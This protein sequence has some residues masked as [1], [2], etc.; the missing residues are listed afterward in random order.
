[1]LRPLLIDQRPRSVSLIVLVFTFAVLSPA[2][3]DPTFRAQSNVVLVPALVRNE[4]GSVIYG[5]KTDDFIIEDAA[6]HRRCIS[7]RQQKRNRYRWS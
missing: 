6:F 4:S 7:T 3:E 2:Q 1:M 5:L